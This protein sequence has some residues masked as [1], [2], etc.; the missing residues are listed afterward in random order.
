MNDYKEL[1]L[2]EIHLATLNVMDY[3][4]QFCEDNHIRYFL[5][6][7]TLIGAVRHKGFIPWDDDFDIIMLREDYD[8]FNRLMEI[9]NNQV[10]QLVSRKNNKRYA[11]GIPRVIDTRYLLIPTDLLGRQEDPQLGVFIDV[12]PFDYFGNNADEAN[13]VM[14]RIKFEN[15]LYSVYVNRRTNKSL[16]HKMIRCGLHY[17]LRVIY[18]KKYN[19]KIDDKITGIIKKK[20]GEDDR[21]LGQVTW[22]PSKNQFSKEWFVERQLMQFEDRYYW[23]PSKYDDILKVSYG[24]YMKLP[25]EEKRHPYHNYK[26]VQKK[27]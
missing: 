16:F 3:I 23:G 13:R 15:T 8:K 17:F 20:T 27:V 22:E 26:I 24:D 18:G 25:P 21:Y 5:A 4:H 9:E 12:Y 14:R 10:F 11:N 2:Q 7:G 6:Y 19:E 1:S